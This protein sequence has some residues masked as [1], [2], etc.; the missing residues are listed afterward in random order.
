MC[1][2]DRDADD[3]RNAVGKQGERPRQLER[4]AV[5]RRTALSIA[6]L[7]HAQETRQSDAGKP[8]RNRRHPERR[9][10]HGEGHKMVRDHNRWIFR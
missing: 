4:P 7:G 8:D 1:Q 9:G 3:G 10:D 2:T 5:Q 6:A